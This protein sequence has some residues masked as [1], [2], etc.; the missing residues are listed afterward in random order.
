LFAKVGR[1]E[2]VLTGVWEFANDR[3]LAVAGLNHQVFT[4]SPE[5]LAMSRVSARLVGRYA[6]AKDASSAIAVT[7]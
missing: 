5:S 6:M 7:A 2:L 3:G 4:F 1:G